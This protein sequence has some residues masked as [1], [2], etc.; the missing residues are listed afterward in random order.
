MFWPNTFF[1]LIFWKLIPKL[2]SQYVG[3]RLF[4]ELPTTDEVTWG[5]SNVT[6]SPTDLEKTVKFRMVNPKNVTVLWFQ[7]NTGGFDSNVFQNFTQ[8]KALYIVE[9][10]FETFN[11][12]F[13]NIERLWM[14]RTTLPSDT[15]FANCCPRLERLFLKSNEGLNFELTGF[16]GMSR[17]HHLN[18]KLQKL[19]H[20]T[21]NTFRGL[22]RLKTL[23]LVHCGI[24]SIA[25]GSFDDLSN[26]REIDIE[27]H[28]ITRIASGVFD[29]MPKLTSLTI[30]G[31][32]IP[33]L[34]LSMFK[35]QKKLMQIGLPLN[36]WRVVDVEQ[37]PTMFPRLNFF[38][39]IGTWDNE[40][41]K[42][43]L[44]KRVFRRLSELLENSERFS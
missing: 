35:N 38:S 34:S 8:V 36:T 14:V 26:L 44:N 42:F 10:V 40:Q 15:T 7:N 32:N 4:N 1:I 39:H 43:D 17:L 20:V 6:L 2:S 31:D 12:N 3:C 27:D 18:L 37:I 5:C 22:S 30:Y 23:T 9:N 19:K 13:T 41:D 29:S 21:R 33:P 11:L 28:N 24:E 25:E 16:R